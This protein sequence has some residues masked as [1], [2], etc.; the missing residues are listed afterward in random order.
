[1]ILLQLAVN[2]SVADVSE[3]INFPNLT[4]HGAVWDEVGHCLVDPS[5]TESTTGTATTTT[6]TT[7]RNA[8]CYSALIS[9]R[10]EDDTAAAV[11]ETASMCDST[12]PY[13]VYECPVKLKIRSA[14][15]APLFHIP[16]P[17][18][19]QLTNTIDVH[20]LCDLET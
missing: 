3:G 17:L 13:R 4:L 15:T 2:G 5:D 18:S 19:V 10:H 6:S 7:I 14:V 16:L 11:L 12:H 20:L 9:F 1:M 8:A